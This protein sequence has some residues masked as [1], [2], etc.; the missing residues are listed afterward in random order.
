[1]IRASA[2]SLADA[3]RAGTPYATAQPA[4]ETCETIDR[5]RATADRHRFCLVGWLGWR[6]FDA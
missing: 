4:F 5:G 6:R 2:I 3:R 1:L